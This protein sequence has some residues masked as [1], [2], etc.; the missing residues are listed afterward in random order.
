MRTVGLAVWMLTVLSAAA[1]PLRFLSFNIWGD[2]FNNPVNEREAGVEA[3]IVKYK[4]DIISLQEVTPNWWKSPMFT[5]LATDFGIVRG[6]EADALRRAGAKGPRTPRQINHEPLLYRKER[7]ALLDSG[8][9]FFHLSL[10][11]EKCVTWTVLEDK[12]DKRRFIAFATHFWWQ[13]NG[14]ESDVLREYNALQILWRIAELRHTW[15]D[16]P[17]IGGG[18][19]NSRPGSPAHEAFRRAGYLN[20]AE[21]A[22]VRSSIASHHGNPVRGADGAYHGA[23]GAKENVPQS[24]IDHLFFTQGI[25]ALK[26][27]IGIDQ[28]ELD[29]SDHSP[30]VVDFERLAE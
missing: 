17:V 26:H 3:V 25:H 18:D 16:L 8:M 11:P 12:R 29:V 30:I 27:H 13:A 5:H 14:P 9:D 7:L 24:S 20:A 6:D 1:E 15:G 23:V 19:L 22:D 4:P 2:Y 21:A 10:G 28:T